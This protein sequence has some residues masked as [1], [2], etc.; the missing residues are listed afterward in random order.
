MDCRK[1]KAVS[2]ILIVVG[3][4]F[5]LLLYLFIDTPIV[6]PIMLMLAVASFAVSVVVLVKYYRCPHCH[7]LIRVGGLAVPDFC[8]N[9]GEAL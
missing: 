5:S 7:T 2:N 6:M 3:V 8:P 1:A 9:C 4:V